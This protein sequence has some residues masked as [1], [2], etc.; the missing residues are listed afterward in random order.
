[1]TFNEAL[2]GFQDGKRIRK[3][4]WFGNPYIAISLDKKTVYLMLDE[5]DVHK[6]LNEFS[7]VDKIFSAEDIFADDW[8]VIE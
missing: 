1:M 6:K 4:S 5:K 7:E 2:V 3:R 8:E